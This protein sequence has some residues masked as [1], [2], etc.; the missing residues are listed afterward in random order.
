MAHLYFDHNASAPV[1]PEAARAR[2][3]AEGLGN[4]SSIHRPGQRARAR[5]DAARE[6]VA[7]LLRARPREIVFTSGGSEANA[8]ALWGAFL[9]RDDLTRTRLLASAIEHPSVLATL[10]QLAKVGARI[11]LLPVDG[12]GRVNTVRATAA[13]GPDVALVSCMLANNETGVLQPA[14][15]LAALAHGAGALFH[16]DAVQAAGRL[17]VPPA[18]LGADLLTLSGHKFGAGTGAGMLFVRD[19][20]PLAPVVA[21]HQ[22]GGRR[23]GTEDVPAL[24]AL[25]AA[26]AAA[27]AERPEATARLLALRSRLEAGL[28]ALGATIVAERPQRLCNTVNAIFAGASGEALLIALD[29]AG[30]AASS[31]AACASGTLEPSHVLLAMGVP[32][33]SARSSVRFSLGPGNTAEEIDRLL[34]ELPPLLDAARRSETSR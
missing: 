20:V 6:A 31:G 19:G 24:A 14:A 13:L 2:A 23:S 18:D 25:A 28:L 27:E 21:G 5:L 15:E 3:E 29:V 11:E 7:G 8:L 32:A 16:C 22:E 4:A 9:G 30:I 12:D 34:G 26:L 17:P 10:G 33:S 1:R